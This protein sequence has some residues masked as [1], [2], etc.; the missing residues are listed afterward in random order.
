MGALLHHRRQRLRA[1]DDGA[2][3]APPGS[4]PGRFGHGRADLPDAVRRRPDH[5]R[6]RLPLPHPPGGKRPGRRGD[7]L[8]PHRPPMRHRERAVLRHGRHHG[9]DLPDRRLQAADLPHLRG[10]PGR[11]LPQGLRPAAAHSSDR[12]GG[13]RRRRRLHRPCRQP[14]PH[15][16]RPR[17][18]RRRS[19]PGLLRPRRRLPGGHRRQPRPRPLRPVPLRR[20]HDAAGRNRRPQRPGSQ[21]GRSARPGCL[22]GRAGRGGDGRREHGQ[23]RP[24][25]RDRVRQ[26][27]RRPHP[28]RLRRRRPGACLPRCGKDRHRPHPGSLRRRRRQRRSRLLLLL[29]LLL[30]PRLPPPPSPTSL[31]ASPRSPLPSPP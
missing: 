20:R 21:G 14:R 13:N 31:L 18:C 15:R 9:K 11:P 6:D 25:P 12:D 29:L 10:R 7:L 19:R 22:D 24:R 3:P 17:K 5:D 27:L 8:R 23:C 4:R 16:R 30:L 28:D 26:D 2:L 1:A